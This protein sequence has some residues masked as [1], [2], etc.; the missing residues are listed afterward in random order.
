MQINQQ[1]NKLEI[2][3][4]NGVLITIEETYFP[5]QKNG[6]MAEVYL[7]IHALDFQ[8]NMKGYLGDKYK[9]TFDG[10]NPSQGLKVEVKE[11]SDKTTRDKVIDEDIT[12]DEGCNQWYSERYP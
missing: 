12:E 4:A 6:K 7:S 1:L 11:I 9:V 8:P 10:H 3:L 5:A 2:M